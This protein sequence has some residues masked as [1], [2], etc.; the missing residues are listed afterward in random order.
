VTIRVATHSSN[1]RPATLEASPRTFAAR[2]RTCMISG[3]PRFVEAVMELGRRGRP[4]RLVNVWSTSFAD[5]APGL[6]PSRQGI[7]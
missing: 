3:A 2:D 7:S 5:P 4:R 1:I 6:P